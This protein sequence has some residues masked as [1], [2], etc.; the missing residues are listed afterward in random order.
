MKLVS[1][2]SDFKGLLKSFL[3]G[4]IILIVYFDIEIILKNKYETTGHW[5]YII[6]AILISVWFW[7]FFYF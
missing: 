5:S 6:L 4:F 1:K 7:N 2:R 3:I